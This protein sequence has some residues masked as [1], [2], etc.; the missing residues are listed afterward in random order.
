MS[1][2]VE[3]VYRAQA[4]LMYLPESEVLDILEHELCSRME[5]Y[6]I[7]KSARILTRLA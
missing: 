1:R 3:N 4:M 5:A 2:F 7:V 6:L